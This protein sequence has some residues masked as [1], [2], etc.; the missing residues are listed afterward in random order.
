VRQKELVEVELATISTGRHNAA[1]QAAV[2]RFV[3]WLDRFGETSYDHQTFFASD[4]ARAAKALYYKKPR[5][6]TLIVSPMIFAEAFVPSARCLFWK[7]QRFPIADAH[8]AMGFA[9]LSRVAA[10]E[11]YY[12]RA[13]HF[14]NVLEKS[15]SQGYERCAWGYP[16][17]WETRGGT[18]WAGTPLITTVP[19]VYEAFLE[20]Y[21]IDG[22]QKWRETMRSI[23]EHALLD[24]RDH[25]VSATASSCSYNPDPKDPGG[26][27]NA[28]AYRAFLL[29]RAAIDFSEKKYQA[30]ADRNL[31]FVIE[32]QNDD[33]SWYYS[34]DGKRDFVDH[35][36]TCFVLKALAKIERLT[37]N[38]GC[39]EAIERGVRYYLNNLFDEQGLPKPFSRRPRLTVYRRELYDCAECINLAVLLQGRFPELDCALDRLI[40]QLG[41]WQKP[42]GSFRSRQLL[43]G[44]DDVPM[45]RWAQAQFF[46]SL[47]FLMS[48]S[49][50]N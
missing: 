1:V 9:M 48:S 27:I 39:T 6:G 17:H 8:Y 15:R 47:C 19:Y 4:W 44:W 3:A 7:K 31:N 13:I 43:V 46:R 41:T 50:A 18:M 42:D 30:V 16:F 40:A 36:H 29:T 24:Y 45:H 35:F 49:S 26:V 25:L 14:L 21:R 32:S 28:S 20:C 11:Q 12:K 23:A 5:L 22:N 2:F 33:G 38:S 10:D 34:T 37:S